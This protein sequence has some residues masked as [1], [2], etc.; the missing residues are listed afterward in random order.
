M[1]Q[2]AAQLMRMRG[3]DATSF[4]GVLEHSGAPRGS[5]YHHFPGGKEQLIEEA[6]RWAG[7]FITSWQREA[8][9]SGGPLGALDAAAELWRTLL[10]ES[11]FGGGCPLVAAT[12]SGEAVVAAKA[13]AAEAFR[14]WQQPIAESL[15]REGLG[16]ERAAA[17]ATFVI[18]AF[19]GAVIL[20]RAERSLEPV[21]RVAAELRTA[22][23]YALEEAARPRP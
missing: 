10:R 23:A 2:S 22:V 18:G 11:D 17:L 14:G 1:I 19:E 3:V 9:E 5:I 12:V 16:R 8:L 15:E 7:E 13:A 21:D 4:S 6:T 20:A